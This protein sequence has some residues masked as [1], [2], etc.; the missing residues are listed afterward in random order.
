MFQIMGSNLLNSAIKTQICM[1]ESNGGGVAK[2]TM[3]IL[4]RMKTWIHRLVE[5]CFGI[6]LLPFWHEERIGWKLPA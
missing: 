4:F 1:P 2:V 3:R 5:G 6:I